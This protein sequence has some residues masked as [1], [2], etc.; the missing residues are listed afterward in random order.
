MIEG[1]IGEG[2]AETRGE[3]EIA[4]GIEREVAEGIAVAVAVAVAVAGGSLEVAE[5]AGNAEVAKGY[6]EV[7]DAVET[8]VAGAEI[9]GTMD[10][11]RE[12]AVEVAGE[13]AGG[14]A[15]ADADADADAG[16]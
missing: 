14:L 2:I 7:V 13:L 16:R 5:I 10:R 11:V 4:E 12:V 1:T 15:D 9:R 6:P 3:T 8:R